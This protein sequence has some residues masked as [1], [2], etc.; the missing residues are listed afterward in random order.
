MAITWAGC[1]TRVQRL[2]R[3]AQVVCLGGGCQAL[4]PPQQQLPLKPLLA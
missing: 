4:G 3:M 1:L 2:P